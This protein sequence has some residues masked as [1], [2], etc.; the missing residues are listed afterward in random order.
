MKLSTEFC[1]RPFDRCDNKSFL[2][3]C[4]RDNRVVQQHADSASGQRGGP[5][6]AL[7]GGRIRPTQDA[8]RGDSRDRV[9]E[10]RGAVYVCMLK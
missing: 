10:E 7:L 9:A 5:A 4:D 2:M 3:R 1:L 6:R 8:A